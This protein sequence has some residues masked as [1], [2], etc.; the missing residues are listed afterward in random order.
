MG[1]L[2]AIKGQLADVVEWADMDDESIFYKWANSEIKKGS[3]LIIRPGQ[4]AVFLY[5]GRVEGIFTE[6]GEYDI[7]S[8]IIPFLSTLAGFKFG[9][10]TGLRAE[11]LF[12]NTREFTVTWGT[13]NA[14]N[15]PVAGLP[16]GMPIRAFGTYTT[17]VDDYGTLIEKIA[18]VQSKFTIDDL[19]TRISAINDQLLMKWIV[20]EGKDMF[21]IEANAYDI[22]A[23]ICEDLNG[24]FAKFGMKA[25]TY[26]IQSVSYPD[27]VREMQEKAAAAAM[28]GDVTHYTQV[29]MANSLDNEGGEGSSTAAQM[30]QMAMGLNLGQQMVSNMNAGSQQA[31]PAQQ[32]AYAGDGSGVAPKYCPNCGTAT[33]GAKYCPNCGT[34]LV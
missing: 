12:V 29:Q 14:L 19:K 16:G 7:A 13:Q 28:V 30:A 20:K 5:Q 34:K 27:S 25:T 26:Q 3:R 1:L 33:N 24:E 32:A 9:F 21:N 31:A 11:V 8:Q 10:K 17:A 15:L 4:D 22:S 18:G 23:G 2:D 6:E